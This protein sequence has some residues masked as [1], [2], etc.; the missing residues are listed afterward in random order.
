VTVEAECG[1][2]AAVEVARYLTHVV[3]T[4]TKESP[5]L[6]PYPDTVPG[7]TVPYEDD[8]DE[9]GRAVGFRH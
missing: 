2:A 1:V 4:V 3:R 6:L 8:G 5:D 7:G 9:E